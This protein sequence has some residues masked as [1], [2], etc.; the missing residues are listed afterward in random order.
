MS[1]EHR[2]HVRAE[3]ADVVAGVASWESREGYAGDS[4]H[5]GDLGWFLRLPDDVVD[6][7]VHTWW[8]AG[9]LAAVALVEGPVARPRIAPG[10]LDDARLAAE[11]ADT[12]ER[13]LAGE[14]WTDAQN[15][16][17]YRAL[18]LAR[19]WRP[20]PDPWV[21]LHVDLDGRDLPEPSG[22]EPTGAA[23]DDRV[24]VQRN[25]FENS[26]FTAEA[27]HRMA[28]GP[29]FSADLDI[30]ARDVDGTPVAVATA[31]SA[32]PGRCGLLEPVATHRDHR[33]GGHGRRVV[34]AAV[35]AL[36]ASGASGARVATPQS[37]AAAGRLYESAGLRPVEVIQA[38]TRGGA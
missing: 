30:V 19:G 29:G 13:L 38:L 4:L 20:D 33:G 16:T 11:V 27:W 17:A 31:W 32:G 14:A 22:V 25:G 26:T 35:R 2:S 3:L 28:A 18:L 36:A 5:A 10:R 12:I 21:V 9:H 6:G 34:Q 37:N 15:G 8:D 23:V 7:A 1:I 24:T